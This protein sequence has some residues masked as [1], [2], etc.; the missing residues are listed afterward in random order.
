MRSRRS[1]PRTPVRALGVV[2][3]VITAMVAV[4][5]TGAAD[6]QVQQAPVSG[7]E[8]YVVSFAGTPESAT[9]A[10]EAAG[11]VVEDVTEEV[12][13]AL[14]SSSDGAFLDDVRARA[15]ITGAARNHA[16]GI[17]GPAC[18]T[19]SRR[20]GRLWRNEWVRDAPAA[21]VTSPAQT[22]NRWPT[23]SGTWT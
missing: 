12:G 8:E 4:P 22:P 21:P 3:L 2:T 14:V 13:V 11:G 6:D 9:A 20:N 5:A 23:C 7:S 1:G 19:A 15:E 17:P 16:V 10:I 18:R